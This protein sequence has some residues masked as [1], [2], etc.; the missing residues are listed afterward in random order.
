ML[1]WCCCS[2]CAIA[3]EARH[4]DRD[5]GYLVAGAVPYIAMPQPIMEEQ[6]QKVPGSRQ[7]STAVQV[8]HTAHSGATVVV[9]PSAPTAQQNANLEHESSERPPPMNPNV[10]KDR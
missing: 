3:Q 10:Q 6:D 1:L 9:A 7:S 4:V 2:P 8:N 5:C